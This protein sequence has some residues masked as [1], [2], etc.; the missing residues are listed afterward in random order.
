MV[1]GVTDHE[2]LVSGP[3]RTWWEEEDGGV[4]V[5]VGPRRGPGS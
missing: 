5:G 3:G 1:R 4:R 2:T